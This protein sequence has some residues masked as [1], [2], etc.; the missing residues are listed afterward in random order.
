MIK[1]THIGKIGLQ[2]RFPTSQLN[3]SA[4]DP[5]RGH[6]A[7]LRSKKT[8]MAEA[9]CTRRVW[10]VRLVRKTGTAVVKITMTCDYYKGKH[11]LIKT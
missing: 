10:E 8:Q 11:S 1:V 2:S 4:E 9:S 3:A 6:V 7:C 5:G